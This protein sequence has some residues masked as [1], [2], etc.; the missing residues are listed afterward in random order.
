MDTIMKGERK[1]PKY[2]NADALIA[3]LEDNARRYQTNDSIDEWDI[4]T[5]ILNR[6][7]AADVVPIRKGKWEVVECLEDGFRELRC[8]QCGKTFESDFSPKFCD[9][10]GADMRE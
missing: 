9:N 6:A 7:S 8:N 3:E 5:R 10:C 4:G 2:V 1:M